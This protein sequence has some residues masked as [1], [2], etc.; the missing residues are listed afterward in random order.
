MPV[1]LNFTLPPEDAMRFFRGKGLQPTYAWQD[2]LREEHDAAF[3]VA[4]MMDVD[5][6]RDVR[7]SVDRAIADGMTLQQ[8]RAELEPELMRRGWWGRAEMA[9]PRTGE[10][11]VVQLGS[12][13]RLRT[14]FQ[15]NLKTSYAAGQWARIQE[16]AE[17]RPYLMYDA[18]MDAATRDE[19]AEW[20][21]TVLPV[22]DP[23]WSTHYPPNGWGCRCSVVQL[24]ARQ[25][26]R[27]GK[28]AP[29]PAPPGGGGV[30]A[31]WDYH[32]G[33]DRLPRLLEQLA[34]KARAAGAPAAEDLVR[35]RTRSSAALESALAI[36][37]TRP[38]PADARDQVV[39]LRASAP[40]HER[41]LFAT[42]LAA[43]VKAAR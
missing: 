38:L 1:E 4:K 15:T 32:P 42:L 17:R 10:V 18:V 43:L 23:W 8:W 41:A 25:L 12:P 40:S 34:T 2:M 28:S 33:R 19:H 29:D 24:D 11:K 36:L 31:G 14:I 13:R 27:L 39:A 3:T 5:L 6:L 37:R 21:G 9:D 22:D 7:E 30:V 26:E 35:R 16:V 20:D